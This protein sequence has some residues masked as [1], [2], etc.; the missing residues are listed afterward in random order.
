[1][2]A[3]A[4]GMDEV[5]VMNSPVLLV[6]EDNAQQ[7]ALLREFAADVL[8]CQV[9]E[10]ADGVSALSQARARRPDLVLLDLYVPPCGG[11]NVL[12]ALRADARLSDV[13]VVVISG[14]CKPEDLDAAT[15]AGISRFISKP[16]DLDVLETTI[17][18]LLPRP[19]T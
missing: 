7:R 14:S 16:Y 10:A 5:P 9:Q 19:R 4:I 6:V 18:E 12:H 8:P 13:P 17:L 11:I 1:M 3:E 15:A 2:L